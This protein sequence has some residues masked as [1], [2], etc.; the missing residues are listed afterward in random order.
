MKSWLN[1]ARMPK[2]NR[3]NL[4]NIIILVSVSGPFSRKYAVWELC[5]TSYGRVKWEKDVFFC[6]CLRS[7]FKTSKF[8]HVGPPMLLLTEYT[9]APIRKVIHYFWISPNFGAR[10]RQQL[11]FLCIWEN[12]KTIQSVL[13]KLFMSHNKYIRFSS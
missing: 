13:S 3:C 10:S 6:N 8:Y 1:S 5:K 11:I 7:I 12:K 2:D 4:E 9:Y